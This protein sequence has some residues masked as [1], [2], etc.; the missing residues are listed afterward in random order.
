MIEFNVCG[1]VKEP[2]RK[3]G[4]AGIDCFVPNKT[5]EFINDVISLNGDEFKNNNL[6]ICDEE[7]IIKSGC[8]IKLP[9]YIKSKIDSNIALL[10]VNK[11]GIAFNQRLTLGACLIDSSYQGVIILHLINNSNNDTYIKYGQK[12]V[13]FVPIHFNTEDI[14]IKNNLSDEEFYTEKSSRGAGGFGSTGI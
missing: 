5:T 9:L 13:Q 12:I 4:D 1:D 7:I 11:S 10:G 3:S 6:K 8:Q 2:Q 14:T